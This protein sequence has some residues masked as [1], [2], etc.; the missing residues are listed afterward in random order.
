MNSNKWT[1][2]R[3]GV[4]IGTDVGYNKEHKIFPHFSLRK[5]ITEGEAE[6]NANLIAAAPE[7]YEALERAVEALTQGNEY[8]GEVLEVMAEGRTALAKARGE[9]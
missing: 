3:W 1:P 6:A 2:G 9:Q 5:W 4:R 7:L 8:Q